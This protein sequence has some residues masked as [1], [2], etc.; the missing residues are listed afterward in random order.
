MF[1]DEINHLERNAN[2][3]VMKILKK[4]N[5]ETWAKIRT[6]NK[7]PFVGFGHLDHVIASNQLQF[8]KVGEGNLDI[9]VSGWKEHLTKSDKT[10][11][12]TALQ[13]FLDNI[14]DHNSLYFEVQ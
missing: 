14:S 4:D 6:K 9:R 2:N 11:P 13:K 5:K 12:N 10:R 8:N 7:E 1:E 3:R